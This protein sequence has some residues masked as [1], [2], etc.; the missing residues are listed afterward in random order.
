ME[1][2][3]IQVIMMNEIEKF[4]GKKPNLWRKMFYTGLIGGGAAFCY[5]LGKY[6]RT[7]YTVASI[8]LLV[9]TPKLIELEKTHMEYKLREKQME[10]YREIKEDSLKTAKFLNAPKDTQDI[11]G[12][13]NK[14]IEATK[15]IGETYKAEFSNNSKKIVEAIS[16]N[17]EQYKSTIETISKNDEQYKSTINTLRE[18]TEKLQS[19]IE[20]LAH[21]SAMVPVDN[22]N[23]SAPKPKNNS[24]SSSTNKIVSSGNYS[25]KNKSANLESIASQNNNVSADYSDNISRINSTPAYYL[26]DADKSDGIIHVYGVLKNGSR[27]D[28]D[29]AS[30]ASFAMSGGPSDGNYVLRN[31]GARRGDLYPGFLDMDDPIGISGAGEYNQHI[32]EI[33]EGRLANRTGIRV[34]NEIYAKLARLVD[35]KK[36]VVY[37]HE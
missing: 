37:V 25:N 22:S 16:K 36:T 3:S 11:T 7:T 12:M 31:K 2:E 13:L 15:S 5:L 6:K 34:P 30:K 9:A 17:D 4:N 24:G 32:E 14:T 28:L 10:I 29:I 21:S 1:N 18:K 8:M 33:R 20:E 23:Y 26:I 35:E 19:T 27:I